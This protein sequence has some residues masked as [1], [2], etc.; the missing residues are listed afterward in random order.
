MPTDKKYQNNSDFFSLKRRLYTT[1]LE[2]TN[3]VK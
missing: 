3:Y 2:N 1:S